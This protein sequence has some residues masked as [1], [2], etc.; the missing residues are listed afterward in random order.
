MTYSLDFRRLALKLFSRM[1]AYR[2]VCA[3][4]G[5]STSTLHRW[6]HSGDINTIRKKRRRPLSTRTQQAIEGFVENNPFCTLNCIAHHLHHACGLKL[7]TKSVSAA[8]RRLRIT[9]KKAYHKVAVTNTPATLQAV[10]A[11]A[12]CLP[13]AWSVDECYFSEKVL[14]S[15]GYSRAGKRLATTLQ[16]RGWQQRSLLMAVH[17]SGLLRY[18][19]ITGS[20][21]TASFKAFVGEQLLGADSIILDNVGFH[22]AVQDRRFCFIPPYSPQYNPVEYCFSVVKNAFRKLWSS[23]ALPFEACIHQAI[24]AL[25]PQHIIHSFQ[26]AHR[27]A[28]SEAA[29]YSR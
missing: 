18:R 6:V 23:R 3:L 25:H 12:G 1:R 8:L 26:H 11:V 28:V 5:I 4:L 19:I 15:H 7:S 17:S 27:L 10:G 21:K 24:Q 20:V 2:P 16:P 22:R 14:P 29:R 13:Q 9:K